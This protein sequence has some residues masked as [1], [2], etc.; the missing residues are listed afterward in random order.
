MGILFDVPAGIAWK[1]KLAAAECLR[2]GAGAGGV[3]CSLQS[4]SNYKKASF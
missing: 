3:A 4:C 2:P 1:W